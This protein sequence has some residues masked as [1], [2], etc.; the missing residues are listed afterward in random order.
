MTMAFP[1]LLE[2]VEMWEDVSLIFLHMLRVASCVLER[3]N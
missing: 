2:K 3:H 1:P